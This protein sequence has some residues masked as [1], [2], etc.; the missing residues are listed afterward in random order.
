MSRHSLRSALCSGVQWRS[1]DFRKGL[2]DWGMCAA[3]LCLGSPLF[4]CSSE[5]Q[6]LARMQQVLGEEAAR[7]IREMARRPMEARRDT[8][9]R[10]AERGVFRLSFEMRGGCRCFGC[11]LVQIPVET[12]SSCF[13]RSGK[14]SLEER[15]VDVF[16]RR[17]LSPSG[18][19]FLYK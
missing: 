16:G 9:R 13:R 11:L 10:T 14:A 12:S 4:G 8:D 3:E 15:L 2:V 5:L 6:L 7:D 1:L 19:D 17:L 18:V